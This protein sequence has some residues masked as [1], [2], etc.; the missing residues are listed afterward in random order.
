[1]SASNVNWKKL[2]R[3]RVPLGFATFLAAFLLSSPTK[4]TYI[5]G[6]SIALVGQALRVWAAGHIEKSREVTRSGPYR[7]IRHPLYVGSVLMGTGFVVASASVWTAALAAAY[8]TVTYVAAVRSEEATLDEKFEGEYSAYREGRATD[9]SAPSTRRFSMDRAF[10]MNREG[11]S[12]SGFVV[13]F[14][15]LALWSF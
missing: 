5:A 7:H 2:A 12:L 14:V 9:V 13:A 8:F 10:G 4:F 11:R 1:M 3:W 15:L 6:L